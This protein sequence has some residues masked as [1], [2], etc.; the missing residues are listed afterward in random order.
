MLPRME[1]PMKR[2]LNDRM[3]KALKPAAAG[4]RYD[5]MGALVPGLGVRVTETGSKTFTLVT[6]YPGSINP[7]RRA[8]GAYGEI[9][10]EQARTKARDWL[11]LIQRGI[12]PQAEVERERLSEQ[13][14]RADTFGS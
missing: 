3:V 9:T 12:D 14:K 4:K 6:R 8:L 5:V 7:A 1:G 13:R 11:A 10:I 2:T